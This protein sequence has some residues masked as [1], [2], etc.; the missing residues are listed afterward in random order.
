M[1]WTLL[2]KRSGKL[3]AECLRRGQAYLPPWPGAAAW[4]RCL[5]AVLCSRCRQRPGG[6]IRRAFLEWDVAAAGSGWRLHLCVGILQTRGGGF[7]VAADR[8]RCWTRPR[9][10]VKCPTARATRRAAANPGAHVE[11]GA[12]KRL[13]GCRGAWRP[14]A[15]RRARNTRRSVSK[16][17]F[18]CCS[19]R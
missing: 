7:D 4:R 10:G 1:V 11:T 18:Y 6:P 9:R 3:G 17:L 13:T 5:T 14:S 12:S 8:Q 2:T 15:R 16:R 19:Q